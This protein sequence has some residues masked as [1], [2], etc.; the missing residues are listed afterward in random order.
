M[1]Q[2]GLPYSKA[3][4]GRDPKQ[5]DAALDETAALPAKH[6]II[7]SAAASVSVAALRSLPLLR[8]PSV[9]SISKAPDSPA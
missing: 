8:V 2:S 9:R 5:T 6:P 7:A 1:G 3:P 4:F